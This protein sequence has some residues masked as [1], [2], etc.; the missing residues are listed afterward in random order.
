MTEHVDDGGA[1][2]LSECR[3][4][5]WRPILYCVVTI[6]LC[7][8][9]LSRNADGMRPAGDETGWITSG[10][11]YTSLLLARD[12]APHAW[13]GEHL[14]SWGRVNPHLGKLIIGIWIRIHP[15]QEPG[16]STYDRMY[17]WA[18]TLEMNKAQGNTPP[19]G[20]L[21]R[22]R[23]VSVL[24]LTLMFLI[25]YIWVARSW[26]WPAAAVAVLGPM[27]LWEM[28][29]GLSL[30][31]TDPP[32]LLFMLILCIATVEICLA[33]TAR[34]VTLWALVFGISMGL[35]FNVK[36]SALPTGA[37]LIAA[38]IAYRAWCVGMNVREILSVSMAVTVP[39]LLLVYI[40]NPVLWPTGGISRILYFPKMFFEMRDVYK[41]I[42]ACNLRDPIQRLTVIGEG[43]LFGWY[44]SHWFPGEFLFLYIGLGVT[45]CRFYRSLRQRTS[46]WLSAVCLV[47]SIHLLFLL[48]F[49]PCNWARYYFPFAIILRIVAGV[50]AVTA[51]GAALRRIGLPMKA[52]DGPGPI[53]TR[54]Q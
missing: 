26:N 53:S 29:F 12:F 54:A 15:L 4:V 33:A 18:E 3:K 46:D 32:Y 24:I 31:L 19:A 39:S 45:A 11:Y 30:A 21:R 48:L 44:N 23:S 47:L 52:F 13:D 37:L 41:T 22:A 14:G 20:L 2:T 28:R 16:D 8:I 49:L 51:V 9:G 38:A 36:I 25:I 50:G 40:L 27:W 17:D 35:A 5:K 6:S 1:E 10:N 7:Y 42:E 43:P 34:K